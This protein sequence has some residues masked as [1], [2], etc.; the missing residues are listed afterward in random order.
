MKMLILLNKRL[1]RS[2]MRSKIR[3][4]AVVAMV[5][6]AVFAGVSFAAYAHT[7]SGMY[8]E[9]YE[10]SENA[11]NLPDL[12]VENPSGTWDGETSASLCEDLASNWPDSDL[13]LYECEPRLRLDGTMFY[14]TTEAGEQKEKLVPAVWHGIGEGSIDRV[15]M[16]SHHCCSGRVAT[17][18]SEIVIDAR[19]ATGME[20]SIGDSVTI[21]A[22]NGRMNFTVVGIGLHS[23]H[24]YYAKDGDLFPAEPGTFATGYLSSEGLERLANMSSGSSPDRH[25]GHPGLQSSVHR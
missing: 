5:V 21:G 15:W 10:D 16:P 2:M 22:G 12:W 14:E 7:V 11:V 9:I 8:D 23:N 20:I 19:V 6:V 1:A 17:E 13:V 24:L 25:L 4:V 3:L 18:E